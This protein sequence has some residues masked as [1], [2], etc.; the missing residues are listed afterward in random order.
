MPGADAIVVGAGAA[1]IG[2]A[3]RL[4]DAGCDVLLIEASDRVGGRAYS[5]RLVLPE[6]GDVTVDL[7][8]GWLHSAGRNPWVAIARDLG[9][10]IDRSPANW[11]EQ[12]RDLC[13]PPDEQQA[14][15]AAFAAMERSALAD[16]GAPDRPLADYVTEPRWRPLLDA[17]SGYI[18]GAFLADVSRRDWAAYERAS[19]DDNWALPG[20]YGTLVARHGAEVPVQL[21]TPARRVEHGGARL[22]VVTDRGT[23][24]TAAVIVAVPTTV[25]ADDSIRFDPPLPDKHH[26]AAQLPLGLAD[27]VFLSVNGIDL[28][29]NA[30]LIGDPHASC[31]GS[32][33][34]GLFGERAIECFL[35]GD[36]AEEIERLDDAGA[37][38]FAI[39]ELVALLGSEWRPRLRLLARSRW[40]QAPFIGGSYSHA[41]VGQAAQRAV[42]AEPI[43]D[44]LFFAGEACHADDFSTCHG[45]L[46]TGWAAADRVLDLLGRRR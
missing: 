13:F 38:A 32:Y 29:R 20:G 15:G 41:R 9:L 14:F 17:L 19:T 21:C 11:G 46:E 10:P 31:T 30:H 18:N 42:L 16:D 44:R 35:G 37:A 26:A 43:G 45:A 25:L 23:L 3:R 39:D 6:G 2:A 28:P 7:G 34:L 33:R 40:R 12:W 1:G 4:H 27:K 5:E 24:D 36:G 8:C 22:R